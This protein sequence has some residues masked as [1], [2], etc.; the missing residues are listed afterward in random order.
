MLARVTD[1]AR[2]VGL[3]YNYDAVHQTNTIKAHEL[4]HFAKEHGKQTEMKE[5]LLSAYFVEGKHVG[6]IEDLADLA[7]EVG[8][9]RS[10][11]LQALT[12]GHYVA[13]VKEDVAQAEAYGISGVPFYVIDGKYGVSG[14]QDPE[15][16]KNVLEQAR[17][18]RHTP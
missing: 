2:S 9:D 17:D 16:F 5:R 6:R 7:Q 1:V 10:L 18:E 12:Q 4:M 11:A 15:T 8:L 13:A 3:Q 14:A